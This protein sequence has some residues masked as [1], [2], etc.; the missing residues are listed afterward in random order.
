M[1]RRRRPPP[2][3]HQVA[4]AQ[5]AQ[6]AAWSPLR[7]P[8]VVA[9]L[10]R[11]QNTPPLRAH[12]ET[13]VRS[14]EISK[15]ALSV[16]QAQARPQAQ[17]TLPSKGLSGG[18]GISNRD[19]GHG[20]C[21]NNGSLVKPYKRLKAINCVPHVLPHA[22]SNLVE[23]D[24][25]MSRC[26]ARFTQSSQSPVWHTVI[27]R[28]QCA[29]CTTM[30]NASITVQPWPPSRNALSPLR[31][32]YT[33]RTQYC[34]TVGSELSHVPVP[35]LCTCAAAALKN[36]PRQT[37]GSLCARR[38]RSRNQ[39]RPAPVPASSCHSWRHR[40]P[41]LRRN[42]QNHSRGQAT[43]CCPPPVAFPPPPTCSPD[44]QHPCRNAGSVRAR[45][46]PG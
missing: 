1:A 16:Q 30:V 28:Q 7:S 5:R 12:C 25:E 20:R 31:I 36:N 45:E 40:R 13:A 18:R 8:P 10:Q 6:P 9:R 19:L 37:A 4:A 35:V 15:L 32:Q 22:L 29:R 41:H 26:V 43:R 23:R 17:S 3:R 34:N 38:Q 24:I 14:R 2:Q 44:A 42:L 11:A 21:N 46:R 33:G 27:T 39:R